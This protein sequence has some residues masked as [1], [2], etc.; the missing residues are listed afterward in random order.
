MLE[1]MSKILKSSTANLGFPGGSVS[2]EDACG[3]GDGLAVR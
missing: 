2:K 3:A 1:L